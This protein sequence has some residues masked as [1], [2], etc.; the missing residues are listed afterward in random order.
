M[1][2]YS[3]LPAQAYWRTG[4]A[5]HAGT[6]K[7]L[8]KLWS[9]T[10]PL[11]TDDGFLTVGSCF[12]QHIGKALHHAG[13][14][15]MLVEKAPAML[16]EKMREQF[17][18]GVFSFR[19]GNVYTAS[20]LLQWLQWMVDPSRMDREIWVDGDE[21]FDPVRPS[22]EPGGF[23]SPDDLFA[24]RDATLSAM[25]QGIEQGSVFIFTL[26]LTETW[27]NAQTGLVYASCPGTQAGDFDPDRHQF[28]NARFAT[29]LNELEQIRDL[30]H[31]VNPKMRMILTVSPVPLTATAVP[32]AHVLVSTVKSK[33]IL[34]AVAG[35]MADLHDDVDYFPSYELVSHPALSLPMFEADRRE[36]TAE[37]VAFVMRHFLAGLGVDDASAGPPRPDDDADA[38]ARADIALAEGDAIC[39]EVEL[40]KYN[41]N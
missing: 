27:R 26:G 24:A 2:P 28:T 22:I 35:E 21:C 19:A 40:D 39:D 34:R 8:P 15:R 17:G 1:N 41:E 31:A 12:A 30:L 25:R 13:L 5:R 20:M 14:N 38:L 29:I 10:I 32:G 37:G 9:P 18:Y 36:V 16:P 33:S 7:L 4:V 11:S 6:G 23:E 3:K